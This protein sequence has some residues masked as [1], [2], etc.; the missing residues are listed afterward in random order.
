[1]VSRDKRTKL[2]NRTLERLWREYREGN[3]IEARNALVEYYRPYA[4]AVVRRVRARLPRTVELGDLEGA[5]DVGLIQAIQHY[6]P[7]R[8]V[9]FE[10][11]CE[12]RVRGAIL[13]ELRRHD[14]LPRPRRMRLNRKKEVLEALRHKLGHDPGD[15][16]LAAELGMSFAEYM[17]LF[18]SSCEAPYLAGSRPGED[19]EGGLALDFLEDPREGGPFDDAHRREM[20]ER[21]AGTLDPESRELLFKRYFEE[22]TLKEI[23]SALA[24]SESRVSKILGRVIDRLKD[25][26]DDRS[27]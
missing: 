5:G 11:F 27:G 24:I 21:I 6:D 23:G 26:F 10:V 18:G 9:P 1:M 12:Y 14:W 17:T 20:L 15:A 3:R 19:G 25:R 4:S 22:R 7:A 8:G 13:D 16:E 2:R